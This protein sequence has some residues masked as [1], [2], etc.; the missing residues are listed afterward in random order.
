ML[1][2]TNW[3]KD[4]IDLDGIDIPALI[5][6]F[7]LSTAEVEEI[8]YKGSDTKGVVV[9][10]VLTCENHP[11]SKKLHL[12]T[13]NQGDKVVSCVCGAPNVRAGLK[14]AFA[15]AG[16]CV[17]G[18][19]INAVT[20]AGYESNGMCCS[21]AEL[22]LSSDNSGI[23]ELPAD[24][25]VGRAIKDL[26]PLDDIVFEVDNKSLT[27]RPDL[28]GHY[29]IAREFSVMTGRPLKP[30]A[31]VSAGD[32]ASLEAL[33]IKS[34]DPLLYRYTAVRA[35]NITVRTAPEYMKI[36]LFYCGM[37]SI[38][39]LADLTNFLMLELGQPMHAFD[40]R[41]VQS[42]EIKR[43]DEPIS[44]TT[45]DGTAR[46]IDPE[47]LMICTN[48]EPAAVAG[49]MGGLDSEIADDTNGL[50]L[51]SANFDGV[52][53]RRSSTRLGLRTDASAR[54]EKVLDP[55][56]TMTAAER[57]I[58]LL[59][60]IDPGA[61]VTSRFSDLYIKKYP[62]REIAFD[63]AYIDRYTG[64]EIPSETIVKTLKAL[65]FE[66]KTDNVSFTVKVPSWRATKDVTI[67]AD[68]VEEITRIYGYDNFEVKTAES[69][70][71]PVS[72]SVSKSDETKIKD[73]LVYK[74]SLHEVHSY[75]WNDKKKNA[76]IGIPEEKNIKII[77]AQTPEHDTVRSSIIPSLLITASENKAF[78]DDFGIFE[79]GKTVNGFDENKQCIEQKKLGFVLYSRTASDEQLYFRARNITAAL[80][81]IIRRDEIEFINV[82]PEEVFAH[83]KNTCD[84]FAGG[85]GFGKI[86]VV[87]PVVKNHIDR[88]AAMVF[89]EL[90]LQLFAE[91]SERQI[92]YLEASKFPGI[93]IDI[94][95]PIEDGISFGSLKNCFSVNTELLRGVTLVGIYGDNPKN[96]TVR[97]K[98]EAKDKTLTMNEING[99]QAQIVENLRNKGVPVKTL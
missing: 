16:G 54:Y 43:F 58:C 96:V 95:L 46:K 77:N 44:F 72:Q 31:K 64:I 23:W 19:P 75:I 73:L 10:E 65:G 93:D 17:S 27:N 86:G 49:I 82:N 69:A 25:E 9:G 24:S 40:L 7:T 55:E 34:D 92:N 79:I 36:R 38:N 89:V 47:T 14:V 20:L 33:D 97:L 99:Y 67:K 48:G 45:L 1:V 35:E 68:I 59:M 62:E 98:F 28:W 84:I 80:L 90:N 78:S 56:L 61:K 6:R 53:V 41:K 57:F 63:K 71:Y 74:Y 21:E 37:R 32:F 39:L 18:N 81:K 26:Y 85:E 15:T 29:G 87:S 42:V 5:H 94:T 66:V 30:Y 2:S 70:L 52:S 50:L 76:E 51:E 60:K 4:F 12:L 11:N 22:G 8:F 13:V 88:K 83:P 3:L 91:L